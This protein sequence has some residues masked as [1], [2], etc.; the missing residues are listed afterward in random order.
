MQFDSPQRSPWPMC[1]WSN[2]QKKKI[3]SE[4]TTEAPGD[5]PPSVVVCNYHACSFSHDL[6][7]R[8]LGSSI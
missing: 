1:P 4:A 3:E 8:K 6:W 2:E 7:L 5:A